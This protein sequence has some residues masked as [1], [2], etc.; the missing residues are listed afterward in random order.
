MNM[1]Q[2]QAVP[3]QQHSAQFMTQPLTQQ[4]QFPPEVHELLQ[5]PPS[6]QLVQS[7]PQPQHGHCPPQP[8]G[9]ES[10]YASDEPLKVNASPS[11]AFPVNRINP[12]REDLP[13]SRAA[14]RSA[15]VS[16]VFLPHLQRVPV[17]ADSA[18]GCGLTLGMPR[19]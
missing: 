1:K 16:M 6:A 3:P 10:A 9:Q 11:A 17:A 7:S 5:P 8:H 2:W 18:V 4:F 15:K 19:S 13:A 14:N 12:L